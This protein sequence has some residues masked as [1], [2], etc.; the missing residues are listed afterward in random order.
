ML[1]L[2]TKNRLNNSVVYFPDWLEGMITFSTSWWLFQHC[3]E[4]GCL[5]KYLKASSIF[6]K[7]G[8]GSISV[9]LCF[10]GDGSLSGFT[11]SNCD[12]SS[13]S[14]RFMTC[15]SCKISLLSG[16]W[17]LLHMLLHGMFLILRKWKQQPFTWRA[18]IG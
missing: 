17:F 5:Q 2:R 16:T 13:L 4:E 1:I 14:V 3:P 12:W 6:P 9:D 8:H 15:I 11:V 10:I 7:A 18:G